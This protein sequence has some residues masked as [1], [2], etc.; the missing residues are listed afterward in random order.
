MA[1]FDSRASGPSISLPV[2][3]VFLPL[4]HD[5]CVQR[6]AAVL[7]AEQRNG[8]DHRIGA[9]RRAAD[10]L[11]AR[12]AHHWQQRLPH[13]GGAP[14]GE[15]Q[16]PPIEVVGAP[17]AGGE[18]VVAEGERAHLQR[19]R[20]DPLRQLPGARSSASFPHSL[21]LHCYALA[22]QLHLLN[23]AGHGVRGAAANR[24]ACGGLRPQ[25]RGADGDR[26][27]LHWHDARRCTRGDGFERRQVEGAALSGG[28]GQPRQFENLPRLLPKVYAR[29]RVSAED[30]IGLI[31]RPP[32]AGEFFERVR[33]VGVA[34]AVELV[35]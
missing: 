10:G 13:Q 5:K 25:L 19:R 14:S 31:G 15:R 18:H 22:V 28:Y 9:E 11:R 23:V 27:H 2:P 34:G 33:R 32:V 8:G 26:L 35:G 17:L 3:W 4:A 1:T 29:E 16:H 21:R 7:R 20:L 6:S 30:E 24:L 12:R